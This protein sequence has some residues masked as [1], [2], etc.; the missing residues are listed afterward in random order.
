MDKI[1]QFLQSILTTNQ[2]QPESLAWIEEKVEEIKRD[3]RPNNFFMTFSAA[4]RFFGHQSIQLTQEQQAQMNTFDKQISI[5]RWKM[6][7]VARIFLLLQIPQDDEN[8]FVEVLRQLW[9]TADM[10]EAAALYTALPLLPFPEAFVQQT[11]EGLRTN[12]VPVFDAIALHNPYPAQYLPEA[13]WNQLYLKAAFM[14]RRIYHIVGIE[15]RA[16]AQLAST[17]SDF[18]HERWA[19]GRT[20]P[21]DMWMATP[22]YLNAPLLKDV[23]KLFKSNKA[24]ERATAILI[25]QESKLPAAKKILANFGNSTEI[26]ESQETSWEIISNNWYAMYQTM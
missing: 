18:V 10:E 22:Q 1:N 23:K 5:Q 4:S 3:F 21:P 6:S 12:I 19:A 13:A 25:C 16:N 14:G 24:I 9:D 2:V 20:V 15:K 7:Q 26:M 11:I 17:I 8:T